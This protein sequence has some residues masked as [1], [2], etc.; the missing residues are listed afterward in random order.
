MKI[1]HPALIRAAGTAGTLFIRGLVKSLRFEYQHLAGGAPSMPPPPE[2]NPRLIFLLWHEYL[3]LP[4]TYYAAPSV[5]TL[6][7]KH[8]DGQILATLIRQLGLTV[9]EGS[10]NRGGMQAVREILR[11]ITGKFHLAITPDGPRGPRRVVQ[12]GAIY[13]AS[14]TGMPIAP[15][16]VAYYRPWR[17]RSWDRFAVPKPCTRAKVLSAT[18]IHV[19][20]KLRTD[21]LEEYRAVVQAEMDRLSALAETWAETNRLSAEG[22]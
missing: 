11:D 16:G 19:P 5:S 4:L 13:I 10:T 3:L 2:P 21:G 1:R 22:R 14:R 12:Q 8:A 15:L 20:P 7:S 6:V 18:P 9:V 17:T